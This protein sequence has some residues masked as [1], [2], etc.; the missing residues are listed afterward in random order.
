MNNLEPCKLSDVDN[1]CKKNNSIFYTQKHVPPKY[2]QRA[3][4]GL[5]KHQY[6]G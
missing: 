1:T 4:V 6:I 3:A 2:R 5:I